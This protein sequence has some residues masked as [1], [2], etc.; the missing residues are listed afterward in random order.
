MV[1]HKV[2][3]FAKWKPVF[4]DDASSRHA[5]G[6][7][8]DRV[9]RSAADPSEVLVLMEWDDVERA[10]L[11][12]RSADLSDAMVRADVTDRPDVWFLKEAARPA[13]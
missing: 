6:S 8:G 11:F 12:V 10:R 2:A 1:R 5:N 9:F 13:F 3:D 7:R 4:D